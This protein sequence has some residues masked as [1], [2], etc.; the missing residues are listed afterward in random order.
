MEL[1]EAYVVKYSLDAA[2]RKEIAYDAGCLLTRIG[3]KHMGT[4]VREATCI[5]WRAI[6]L[7][8]RIP[9]NT[10]IACLCKS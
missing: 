8:R 10:F 2:E 5:L 7:A 1:Y 4:G 9:L 3:L 6:C